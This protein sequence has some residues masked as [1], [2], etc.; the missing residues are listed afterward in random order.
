MMNRTS[1]KVRDLLSPVDPV[2]ASERL[3]TPEVE[4]DLRRVLVTAP[5]EST[6]TKHR[7]PRRR[8]ARRLVLTTATGFVAVVAVGA[9]MI[10]TN[11]PPRQP[12]LAATPVPL[13]Y[14]RPSVPV[15]A[16]DVL[17]EI[18]DRTDALPAEPVPAGQYEHQVKDSWSL[19]TRIDGHVVSS[20]IIPQHSESWRA[21]DNS[22]KIVSDEL[23][24]IFPD[25]S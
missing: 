6:A 11:H 19:S 1:R 10:L 20:A 15:S 16:A 24:P 5:V 2:A 17:N 18:A 3:I 12:D 4:E 9:A 13:A 22:G 23:R 21:P 7:P 14:H 25:E 8:W